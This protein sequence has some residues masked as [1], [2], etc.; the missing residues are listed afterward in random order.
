M[1]NNDN[2]VKHAALY[3]E[4]NELQKLKQTAKSD[5]KGALKEVAKQFEQMFLSMMMKSMREANAVLAKDSLM[6]GGQVG[7]YQEMLDNQITMDISSNQG[8]GLAD[9]LARQLGKSIDIDMDARDPDKPALKPLSE[10]DRM[11]QRAMDNAANLAASALLERSQTNPAE[12]PPHISSPEPVA[13]SA[14]VT[15]DTDAEKTVLPERFESPEQ[16]VSSLM[17]L[18]E[19]VAGEIGVDPKVL[20]AQAALE[21]GWGRHLIRQSDG[22]NS[23]NLFNIKAD[24]RWSGERALVNTLEYNN[25][26]PQQQRAAF[27]AYDSYESSFRDY[28]EFLKSNPRYQ[29]ALQQA[30]NPV[31]YLQQLQQAGYATDPEYAD[32]I[33]R[34]YQGEFLASA[35]NDVNKG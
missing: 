2:Q 15:S 21:T 18:A 4:L 16:F 32:K 27:R 19:E 28:V 10:S 8:I 14:A 5:E 6:N 17:P 22:S 29:P 3:T 11:L 31:E 35:G 33:G 9:V 30:T 25:G 1:I 26:V 23:H 24:Q 20:L 13:E 12:A 7:F 34:I